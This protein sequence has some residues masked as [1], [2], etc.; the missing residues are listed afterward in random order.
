M[1]V[2]YGKDAAVSA[3][4]TVESTT[5]GWMINYRGNLVP[6]TGSNTDG[7][8]G[9]KCGNKDWV[10]WY[11]MLG[12]V[13]AIFPGDEFAGVWSIDGSSGASGD[14][15]C[16]Q[17]QLDWNLEAGDY[18]VATVS[19]G[20]NGILTVGSGGAADSSFPNPS[21]VKGLAVELDGGAELTVHRMRMIARRR[22]RRYCTAECDGQFKRGSSDLDIQAMWQVYFDDQSFSLP[23]VHAKHVVKLQTSDSAGWTITWMRI[24]NIE[25]FGVDRYDTERPIGATIIASFDGHSE[26][27]A[28]SV[29]D[30]AGATRWP[31]P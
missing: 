20:A 23:S 28:G 16:E 2:L 14:A 21:C 11:R 15:R 5:N 31:L 12:T 17:V 27:G 19:F 29:A 24:D 18:I 30:A 26:S 9:R 22:L 10:G 8:F 3:E 25:P 1:G 6:Y 4:G 7:G 13:P